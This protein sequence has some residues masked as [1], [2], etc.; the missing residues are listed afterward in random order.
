MLQ[1]NFEYKISK[2]N[3]HNHF[4][5]TKKQG[6]WTLHFKKKLKHPGS[7]VLEIEGKPV[8]GSSENEVWERPL[9]LGIHIK[10]T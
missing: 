8:N 4:E 10:V 5:M 2:G 3:E 7:F 9:Y 1:K 6:V